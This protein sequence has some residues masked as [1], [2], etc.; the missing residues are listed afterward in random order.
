MGPYA[1]IAPGIVLLHARPEDGV[2]AP[3]LAVMTL[4]TPVSFG[5]SENDP[6]DLVFA[7]GAVDHD[8]HI[9]T[10]QR[11]MTMLGDPPT[12][13]KIRDAPDDRTLYNLLS[14]GT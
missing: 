12:M 10:L 7:L 1:V 14:R 2:I 8:A 5:H 6:V 4:S 13:R 9:A 11:L 3:C